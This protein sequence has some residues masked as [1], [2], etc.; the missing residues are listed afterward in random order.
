MTY[1]PAVWRSRRLSLCWD[2]KQEDRWKSVRDQL[3]RPYI[4]TYSPGWS[5]LSRFPV[6]CIFDQLAQDVCDRY[7]SLLNPLR[8][9]GFYNQCE[10]G[11]GGKFASV[12][13]GECNSLYA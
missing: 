11:C 12:A 13:S 9:A 5:V 10:I 2:A 8:C 4:V 7:V 1:S 3:A 6:Q